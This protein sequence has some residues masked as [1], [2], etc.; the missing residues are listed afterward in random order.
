MEK[1]VKEYSNGEITVVW[2]PHLCDHSAVCI[3]E[4]PKVFDTF[5]RPW[6]KIDAASSEEIIKVVDRCP[7]KALT[8]YKNSE[9]KKV[10]NDLE[11]SKEIEKTVITLVKNGSIRVSGNFILINE[12]N[13]PV[14]TENSISLCRCGKSQRYPFCDGSHKLL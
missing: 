9:G 14:A 13:E 12:D 1:I 6:I 2:Q 3:R 4:L 10:N 5:S 11:S 8:W 7:T